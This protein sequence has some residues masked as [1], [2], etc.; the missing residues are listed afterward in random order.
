MLNPNATFH[1][2]AK[3]TAADVLAS[4]NHHRGEDSQFGGGKALLASVVEIVDNGDHSVT[5]KLDCAQ[6]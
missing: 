2:G 6:C 4:M 5:F 1:S 3:V